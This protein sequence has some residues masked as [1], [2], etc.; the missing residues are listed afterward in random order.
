[1][2]LTYVAALIGSVL[3]IAGCGEKSTTNVKL[4][5]D[6]ALT[7]VFV[8]S[9][10][11][12]LSY[13]SASVE[14]GQTD[15]NGE[16]SYFRGEQLS[17]YIGDLVFPETP[18]SSVISPLD[19]FAT[20][21]A[22]NQSVVNTIRLLQSLDTDGDPTNGI[23]L[24][25][26]AA[27]VAT[28]TLE[29][30]ET[31]TDFFNQSDA[32]FASDVEVWLPAAGG[33]SNTLIDKSTALS[34]FVS[35][36]ETELGTLFPNTF[37]VTKFTGD[38][39]A[40]FIE[41]R[42][43]TQRTFTFTPVD[44]NNLAGDFTLVTGDETLSGNYEFAFGRKVLVLHAQEETHYLI[45]RA[46]NTVNDVYSLCL[47]SAD[48]ATPI[49]TYVE[50]CLSN[51]DP[52]AAVFAF[53]QAQAD[54]ESIRLEEAANAIQAALE[55]NFDTDTD[56]FFSSSYKR[57]SD[58]PDAG[59]LYYVTGGSPLVDAS[60]GQLTLEGDRFSI[61]NA[62]ANPGANTSGTDT[63]GQGIYN[64]SEGFT[65]SFDIV[66]VG[67]A[68]SFSLYV[69]NNTTGQDNSIHGAASKFVSISLSDGELK[70]GTRYS[71]TY[72]PGDDVNGG[73]PAASDAKILDNT[74]T[75]SFF[76]LRTDSSGS[77]TLDNLKIETV[78]D[79]VDVP[80]AP[81]EPEPTEP[82]E[83]VIIPTTPLPLSYSFAGISE[84]IFSTNFAAIET[85]D[86]VSVPMLTKTGGQVTQVSN[87]IELDGGRF[88][89]GNT[90]PDTQSS[91]DD[92]SVN[93]ALDLS[94][95][96]HVIFD[97]VAA[98]DTEGD[99]KF[100]IYVDNNTSGSA[101]S[102]LGGS[103]RFYNE[104]VTSLVAGT[105]VT[106]EGP[107]A[108]Q[109]SYLQFRTESGSRVV[110]DNIRI[111]YIAANV[112][113]EETFETDV[114]SFFSP[115][116][117][118]TDGGAQT[119]FY[120]IT[121]G[122]SGLTM[123]DGSLTIDSA[124]FT[125]GNTTPDVETS[126]D[127]TATTGI[128]DL[129]RPYM[130]SMDIINVEDTEGDNNF[131]IYADNNTS[132]SSK[133]IH[134]GD[135]K[136]FSEPITSLTAGQR[137][138]IEGFVA[139]SSSFLQLRTESGGVVTIDNLV[140]TYLDDG[141]SS[142][143]F[144]CD[145]AP[146]LYF[147]D[148]FSSG[149]F[150]NFDLLANE[151]GS[152]GAQGSFD[153]LDDDGNNVM[154]YTAGGEGGEILLVK[155]SVLTDLPES[156]DYFVEAR[157]RPRQN[158]TTRN[159]Q[160]FL[161]GRYDSVGNWF[162]GGLNVQNASTSTQVE[163][164]VSKA[165]SISRPLQ[166]KSPIEIGEK[167]GVDGTWYRVRIDMVG[168]ELTVYLNGENLGST[169]DSS[170]SAKGLIGL[171][172]NNRSFELDD[173]KVGDPSERPVQLTLDYA[174]NAWETTT[175]EDPL[176]V[177][178]TAVKSDGITEDEFSV[179]SSDESV[180]SVEQDG[181]L[182]VLSA[183]AE[184]NAQVTFTSG[185]DPALFKVLSVTVQEGFTMPSAT[186]G[187]LFPL[188][189]P[190]AGQQNAY[191]D[192]L[193]TLTFDD[194]PTLGTSGE[195]RIYKQ[196]DDSIVDVIS[197]GGD[198]DALG[199]HGQDK[200]RHV[201]YLPIK[202][203]GNQLIVKPHNNVL[204]YGESYY[205]AISNGLVTDASLNSQLFN[206]LG[207][208][209][210]WTFTTRE[211]APTGTHLL[212]D[213]DGEADF[214]SLQGAL[215]YVMENLPKD[216]P[217]T[218]TLRDGEYE[219]LLF[220][221]NQNNVTIQG[222]S[223]DNTLVYYANYDSLN[224]GSGKSS[225]VG[226]TVAE[227][228]RSVF[229]VEGTDNLTLHNFTLK[230][231]HTRSNAYSNQAE[232]LYFNNDDGRL[233]A[234]NMNFISEQDTLQLKGYS[235]FYETLVAGNVDF[236]W[237]YVNTALFEN[238]EIRT[239]GDSKNGNPDE[240]TAGGYVLQARVPDIDHKG[241]I[242]LNS[243]FTNG[244][245]PLGNGVLDNSTYIARSGGSENYFDN[246]TL[247]NNRFDT[248]IADIGW[249][250]EGVRDQPAPNP[251][252]ATASA[253]WREYGS[254]DLQGNA[255]NLSTR[256]SAYLLTESDVSSL[257]TREAI[258]AH[259]DND[260]GWQPSVP[261]DPV[262]T[263]PDV[264]VSQ[265]FAQ[266]NYTLTG[267]AGG[268]VVTVNTGLALQAALDDAKAANTPVTIYVD[269]TITDVNNGSSG[270]P[271]E[272]RDMN[273]VSIIGVASRGELDG[274]GILIKRANNIII[275]NL[276]IHHVLTEGKDAIA[277]EGDN[278]G[279]TTSHIWIDHNE[280]YSTLNVDK[281]YYDG[282]I[283]SKRGAKSITISY[284]YLHDHWKGSLHGHTETDTDSANTDRMITFHHNR[285]E[286]IESRLP[287][288]RYGVGHLYNNYYSNI[289]STAINSR[290]GAELRI[291]N[292][293][294]ENTQNPI[295]SF[296]SDV[297]GYWNTSGNVFGEGVT[298]TTPADGDVVAGPE[299]TPTS[300]YEVPYEYQ[301]DDADKT[302][303]IVINHAGVGKIKQDP[304]SIP[305]L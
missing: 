8:D 276:K 197:M 22:F 87:G 7:G 166:K 249:A 40:P 27:N 204:E 256:E 152:N 124:R 155:D 103:S 77:I 209:A 187:D 115:S 185:E 181:S 129:S 168:D 172:T 159:K 208:T 234:V 305:S 71:Y 201:N 288:F 293:V 213:D 231:T 4:P 42:Q 112:L 66:A 227:G 102:Y 95:P 218:I 169:T 60:T 119:P 158:S 140:I 240:D 25:A 244:P 10:V 160:I 49:A 282:L 281:D 128:L 28:V 113:L 101:N 178:V 300:S 131:I 230:N 85:A 37:D 302:K 86:G 74:V 278:D 184:G 61:G 107:I 192:G 133:S 5:P 132:S 175:S 145:S 157:I 53:T 144:S 274:I 2:K 44:E 161:L 54:A 127:D 255:L 58:A 135:A 222:E 207:K 111:E 48:D 232:A 226:A 73:D 265:G 96:Y 217:A 138:S 177:H 182:V 32:D 16:F 298:W 236:I 254:M 154:R 228:G 285:F 225:P 150:D 15:E 174:T 51:D 229:L 291:N 287:L 241:F 64:L 195:V 3:V 46:Y 262:V 243:R 83:P 297:V 183:N 104:L 65:I 82:E 68:G 279:S 109:N 250:G 110:I 266:H 134:G 165:G 203:E 18:A 56:T 202:V 257:T 99:N 26:D 224:S 105:T 196:S 70:A 143:A 69:D 142:Q 12:G 14:A 1:M 80:T 98:E 198:I 239:I 79:A 163:I 259:Y 214:R 268:T 19:L 57:L 216:Q 11:S 176:Y 35:Y 212:V 137:L 248:H 151:S 223:R 130:I 299:A 147:C 304:E 190:F 235:W 153:I 23:T 36:L 20:D 52:Q 146:T 114:D 29:E 284:N 63:V 75:N 24:S 141:S 149:S 17:F 92:T 67:S 100:Q 121:G 194:A 89:L 280:L 167:D 33:A 289:A 245:G 34:H 38:V 220:L 252:T 290:Q 200:L 186:Y 6:P 136:F 295:V 93:G 296:Y 246:I 108:S 13:N 294:F 117:K 45:S 179:I 50:S 189:T 78:A 123:S 211:A 97:V 156:G 116:Y 283:D 251:V 269:G 162:A 9:P 219:E 301:L 164:A 210:N 43:V 188:T 72:E 191:L 205:V 272:I 263:V 277:I 238:S 303:A 193:L 47:I 237:G 76:Q 139:T 120:S 94:R 267:G 286:N 106:V 258:F 88:T 126:A 273:D 170:Y 215:N 221:R 148:D 260:T 81:T 173:L 41:N 91:A 39:Y 242:F 21:N 271:I 275:R 180:V 90:T 206:G 261:S 55:E 31:L 62:A 118:A 264:S 247:I 292:N 59:A 233:S 199:Y 253:G 171:F 125:L 84:D 30:G 122:S 270:A